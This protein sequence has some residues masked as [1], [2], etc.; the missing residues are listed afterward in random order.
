[1]TK[2]KKNAPGF[3]KKKFKLKAAG[4]SGISPPNSMAGS[5]EL[6]D[7]AQNVRNIM[8]IKYSV[9]LKFMSLMPGSK[10]YFVDLNVF[11]ITARSL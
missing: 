6:P 5:L 2:K 3:I 4:L 11:F 10:L 9:L 7:L 8:V 1:L